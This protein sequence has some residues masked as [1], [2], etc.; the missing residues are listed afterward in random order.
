MPIA[1]RSCDRDLDL[2]L[3]VAPLAHAPPEH[4][5]ARGALGRK[6]GATLRAR[7]GHGPLPDDDPTGRVG[8]AAEERAAPPRAALGELPRAPRLGA[9]DAERHGLRG[10]AL[11]VTRARDELPEAPVLDDHR[12]AARRAE[13]VGGLVLCAPVSRQVPFVLALGI[14]RA[15]DEFPVPAPPLDQPLAALG[16]LFPGRGADLDVT[17]LFARLLEVLLEP[18]IKLPNRID[19]L[20]LSLLDLVERVLHL[21]GE[22]DIHDLWEE[23][24]QEVGHLDAQLGRDERLPLATHVAALIDDRAEDRRVRGRAADAEL[25]ESLDQR[26]LGVVRRRLR[27]GLSGIE[28]EEP[29]HLALLELRDGAL[30]VV[31]H[32]PWLVLAALLVDGREPLE[33]ERR[34]LGAEETPAGLDICGH[35]VVDRRHHLARQEALPDEPIEGELVPREELRHAPRLQADL[36]GSDR[37]VRLLGAPARAVCGRRVGHVIESEPS[38]DPLPRLRLRFARHADPVGAHIVDDALRALGSEVDPLVELLGDRHRLLRGEAELPARL[39]LQG[40]GDE[41]RHRAPAALAAR[42]RLDEEPGVLERRHERARRVPVRQRHLLAV[43]LL[44]RRDELGRELGGEPRV[45]RPVLDRDERL[46][47]A[48]AVHDQPDGHRLHPP[49]REPTLDLVPEERG[50]LVADETVEHAARLLR[51]DLLEVD[52]PGLG[53]RAPHRALGD[54]VERD[55]IDVVLADVELLGQVPADRLALAVGIRGDVE[56]VGVRG[57]LLQ[58]VEDLLL[59]GRDD[60]LRLEPLLGIDAELGLRQIAHMAHRRFDDEARVQILLDRLHLRG[61]FHYDQR[62]LR[63]YV[64]LARAPT[65]THRCPVSC[66][67]HP[68]SSSATSVA[69][70]REGSSPPRAINCSMC[71]GSSGVNIA[72]TRPSSLCPSGRGDPCVVGDDDARIMRR[73]G[74]GNSDTTSCQQVISLAPSWMSRFVPALVAEVILPGTA[75]TSRPRSPAKPAVIRAPLRSAASTT[76]TP[77]LS[78]ASVRLRTGKWPASAGAPRANCDTSAPCASIVRASAR[79]S[80]G[81]TTSIPHPRTASVRPP[82]SS[83]PRCAAASMPRARPLTIVTPRAPSSP[84]SRSATSTPYGVASR[85]PTIASASASSMVTAPRT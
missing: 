6:R 30:G 2:P 48:L 9:R 40:R 63:H 31:L 19:P 56:G 47:L 44:Q 7:L 41:R 42:D 23:G 75:N 26:G 35:G 14:G 21:R 3:E 34:A 67:A 50:E 17:P 29:Q 54:L 45:E 77:R 38:R 80:G 76:T 73:H 39:L 64:L 69:A 15:G 78:P 25:L 65:E 51:V 70:T 10:L 12:L 16:A 71:C 32:G 13:L 36:G 1:G 83:A 57:R 81:Y 20:P 58:L 46:D 68:P 79:F 28:R 11:R 74:S 59:P 43:D 60:V 18:R 52:A 37:L 66:R 33:P 85:A 49:G 24:L 61:R 72:S 62:S 82:A 84:A 55:A 27:E 8:G 53:E 5:A 22:L 4:A